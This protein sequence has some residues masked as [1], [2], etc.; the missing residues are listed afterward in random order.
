MLATP[1]RIGGLKTPDFQQC[2]RYWYQWFQATERG[3]T[4]IRKDP[5]GF[6]RT[7][8]EMWSPEGWFDEATFRRFLAHSEIQTG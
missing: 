7:M 5:K 3:E 8:W 6:A 1:S 4:A 2:S